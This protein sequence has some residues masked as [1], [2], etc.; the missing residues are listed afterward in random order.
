MS[1]EGN[2][3]LRYVARSKKGGG[4][5]GSTL[6][7]TPERLAKAL[8]VRGYVSAVITRDGEEVGRVGLIDGKRSWWAE[9]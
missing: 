1:G 4:I 2:Y 8:Y 3:P 6:T 7:L 9:V 5:T